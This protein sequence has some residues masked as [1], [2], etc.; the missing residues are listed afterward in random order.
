MK[1][2]FIEVKSKYGFEE[3]IRV[4]S[5]SVE[6][7]GDWKVMA[8]HQLHKSLKEHQYDVLPVSVIE[9]CNPHHSSKILRKDAERIYAN[10][11]PCRIAVY[12]KSDNYTYLSLMNSG[13]IAMQIGGVVDEVMNEAFSDSIKFIESVKKR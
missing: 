7:N 2:Q 5:E 9:I 13:L 6:Q 8:T 12:N 1:E 3:T 4:L 10:M 11:M